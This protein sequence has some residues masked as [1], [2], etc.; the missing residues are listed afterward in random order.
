MDSDKHIGNVKHLQR[1]ELTF[2]EEKEFRYCPIIQCM[3]LH[4]YAATTLY[5]AFRHSP[6]CTE[7]IYAIP[8]VYALSDEEIHAHLHE[9]VEVA[10]K[11]K[12]KD[13]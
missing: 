5:V 2:T 12:V 10:L 11:T 3:R 13:I 9:M 1:I 8:S 6:H 4:E 7:T